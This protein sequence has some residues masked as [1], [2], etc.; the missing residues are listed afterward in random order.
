MTKKSKGQLYYKG[1]S[2]F[3]NSRFEIVYKNL[4][5]ERKQKFKEMNLQKKKIVV[6]KLIRKGEMI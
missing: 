4:S 6:G 1:I 2:P 3:W 5:K